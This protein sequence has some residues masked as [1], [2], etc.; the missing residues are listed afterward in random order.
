MYLYVLPQLYTHKN[1]KALKNTKKRDKEEG[2]GVEHQQQEGEEEVD[3]EEAG[4]QSKLGLLL[5]NDM[6]QK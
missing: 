3:L 6:L 4:M 1:S 5:Y 2:V